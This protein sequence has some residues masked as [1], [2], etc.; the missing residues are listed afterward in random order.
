M[1]AGPKLKP[2]DPHASVRVYRRNLPHW[3][4]DGCTYSVTFGLADA[5]PR[6]KT[7]Q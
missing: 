1:P 5:I 7:A 6:S 2:F 4:Q 3:R